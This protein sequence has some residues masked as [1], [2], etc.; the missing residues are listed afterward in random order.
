MQIL[1]ENEH[2]PVNKLAGCFNNTSATYKFYW[3]L[4]IINAIERGKTLISKKE[5]FAGMISSAWYTVNYFHV[6][7]GAQ[8]K[9]QRAIEKIKVLENITIDADRNF[10]LDQLRQTEN[11][12]TIQILFYF[13]DLRLV[14]HPLGAYLYH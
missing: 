5:L 14:G 2:L 7:F 9:L 11:I 12:E 8:D 3:F 6:S 1:P 4:S 10:I 13:I